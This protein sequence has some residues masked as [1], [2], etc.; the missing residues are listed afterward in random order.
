[1]A[2]SLHSITAASVADYAKRQ[3][4]Q[5][6]LCWPGQVVLSV[7][8]IYWT[9]AVAS[10]LST[11][12]GGA[13]SLAVFSKKCSSDLQEEVKLVRGELTTLQRATLG[14]LVVVD[15]HARDVVADMVRLRVEEEADFTWQAQLRYYWENATVLVRMLNAS[16]AYGCANHWLL[17][18]TEMR[19]SDWGLTGGACA[20]T[21]T[22]ATLGAS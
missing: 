11:G 18:V 12:T 17:S 16:A 4:E 2:K 13:D 3:R 19:A 22:W 5:W 15:V 21:N 8:Q 1:M 9:Q 10:A 14:A 7:S 6:M 20:A